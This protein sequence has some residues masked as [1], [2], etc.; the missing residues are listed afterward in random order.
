[1]AKIAAAANTIIPAVLALEA[2]GFAVSQEAAYVVAQR[3]DDVYVADDP[4]TV[5]GLV[6]LVQA[7]GWEWGA[8][9]DEID[10]VLPRFTDG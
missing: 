6:A 8:S 1:M 9:D 7:R 10:R 2:A 4:V 3:G 5:L